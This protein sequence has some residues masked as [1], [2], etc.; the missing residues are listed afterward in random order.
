MELRDHICRT[1]RLVEEQANSL[2]TTPQDKCP[3]LAA[4]GLMRCRALLRGICVLEDAGL[5]VL[6]GI[7]GR[8]LWE[9]WLLSLH[10]LL[11]RD[12][13]VQEVLSDYVFHTRK[14]AKSFTLTP[15]DNPDWEGKA[16]KLNYYQLA[17]KLGR[18]LVEAGETGDATLGVMGYDVNYRIHSQFA[19]HAG[20]STIGPFAR[21]GDESGSVDPEPSAPFDEIGQFSALYT[22]HLA[23]YV[24][25]SV[26]IATDSVEAAWDDVLQF[27]KSE[28]HD[29]PHG[30]R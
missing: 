21:Y 28:G 4:A 3:R 25:K 9:T 7:L 12:E 26:G 8:A 22:L 17:E 18:L 16:K 14:L 5:G 29:P 15:E 1:L 24:F 6:A 10:V 2:V 20:L 19:A 23:R 13:A 11:R 30:R 27:V